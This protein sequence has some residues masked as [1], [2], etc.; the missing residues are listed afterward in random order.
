MKDLYRQQVDLLSQKP[1]NLHAN[2]RGQDMSS[3]R[4]H[5]EQHRT[6]DK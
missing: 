1:N 2:K 3:L 5:T 6:N 4:T